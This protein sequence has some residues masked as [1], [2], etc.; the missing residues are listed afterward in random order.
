MS[1]RRPCFSRVE[2]GEREKSL[3]GIGHDTPTGIDAEQ[4]RP[5]CAARS[6]PGGSYKPKVKSNAARRESEGIEVPWKVAKATGGKGPCG[7]CAGFWR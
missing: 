3:R 7:G 1:R 6:G 5:V 4:E 2:P